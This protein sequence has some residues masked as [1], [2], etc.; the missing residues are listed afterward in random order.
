MTEGS[1]LG[2]VYG[3]TIERIKEQAGDKS[4]LG[5]VALMWVS[6]VE[7]LLQ[8]DELCPALAVKLGSTD[9]NACNTPSISTLVS[10]CQELITVD[11]EASTVRLIHF[12]LQEHLSA[13]PDIFSGPH[14][15]MAEIFLTFLNSQQVKALS[16]DPSPDMQNTPFLE[17]CSVYWGAYAKREFS[18]CVRSLAAELLKENYGRVPTKSLSKQRGCIFRSLKISLRLVDSTAHRSSKLLKL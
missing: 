5:K 10:C 15:A 6:H 16:V 1:E 14:S 4:R 8:A 12:T 11:K 17:Y 9:F 18:D 13:H 3:A 2:D 7:R